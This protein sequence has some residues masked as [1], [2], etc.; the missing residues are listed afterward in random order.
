MFCS[1]QRN[2][3]FHVLLSASVYTFVPSCVHVVGTGCFLASLAKM[4]DHHL[5][6]QELFNE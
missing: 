3:Q 4:R 6:F 5:M 2:V 1:K